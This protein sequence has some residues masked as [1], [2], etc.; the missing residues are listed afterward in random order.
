M[1]SDTDNSSWFL[2]PDSRRGAAI[3]LFCLPFAGAGASMYHSWSGA[4]PHDIEV[5]AVQ[6]PGRETRMDETRI[7]DLLLVAA[8]TADA[9]EPYVDR[10]YALFGYSMGALLAYE[11]ARE[12]RRRGAPLPACLFVAAMRAPHVPDVRPALSGLPRD[13]FVDNVNYYFQPADP[14]WQTPELLEFFLPILRDDIAMVDRYE[15]RTEGALECPIRAYVGSADRSTPLPSV[16]A[17][18]EH[19]SAQFTMR[20]FPGAHFF[21]QT[22]LSELQEDI[23]GTLRSVRTP[24]PGFR[25][26]D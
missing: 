7:T 14:A 5:R 1:G 15:H 2:C 24:G 17:W 13:Q 20:V 6:L 23:M 22:A 8:G 3:R 21:L 10:P 11:T 25:V 16:E 19:T 18:G 9:L 4:F 26:I 12:L